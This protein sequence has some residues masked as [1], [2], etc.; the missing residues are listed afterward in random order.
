VDVAGSAQPATVKRRPHDRA[1]GA[2]VSTLCSV[3]KERVSSVTPMAGGRVA[4]MA[5]AEAVGVEATGP[6][7]PAVF[8]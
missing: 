8:K 3:G 1:V 6:R 7:G 2:L 4:L 5:M